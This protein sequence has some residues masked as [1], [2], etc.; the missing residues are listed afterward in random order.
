MV[1][2]SEADDLGRRDPCGAPA[3]W[4]WHDVEFR[5]AGRIEPKRGGDG[6]VLVHA[7]QGRYAK[8][9]TVRL[10]KYGA[11]PFCEFRLRGL[12]RSAGV[13]VYVLGG[14]PVYVGQAVDL[15]ARFYAYGRISPKNCYR[16]GRE[17]NCRM[18]TLI[19][20]TYASGERIDVYVHVTQDY[21]RL[22]A[23]MISDLRPKWN[24]SGVI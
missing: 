8:R 23:S 1:T 10:N 17:T 18:N 24:R 2:N 4:R 16:G 19:Y 6:A 9:D 20:D 14:K 5:F 11:G 15:D 22:E 3:A 13:Y 21:A 12:P 7:P